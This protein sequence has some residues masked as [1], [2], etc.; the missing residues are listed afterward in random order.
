M[1]DASPNITECYRY[2]NCE[3]VVVDAAGDNPFVNRTLLPVHLI[4]SPPPPPHELLKKIQIST[5]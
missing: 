2:G 3:W 4:L 5:F 1:H